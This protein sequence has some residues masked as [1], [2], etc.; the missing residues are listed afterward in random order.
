[1]K[2]LIRM[3]IGSK[4]SFTIILIL[5]LS[6]MLCIGCSVVGMRVAQAFTLDGQRL[7][8]PLEGYSCMGLDPSV[9]LRAKPDTAS[10]A[11]PR[12]GTNAGR[13]VLVGNPRHE[14][15][16]FTEIFVVNEKGK[17]WVPS[18]KLFPA[19]IDLYPNGHC[20]PYVLKNGRNILAFLH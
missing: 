12:S 20:V 10:F 15:D 7:D 19:H 8:R 18:D 5:G 11:T 2:Q 1:M 16:G 3:I 4:D 6:V 9:P 13:G 17:A 14:V